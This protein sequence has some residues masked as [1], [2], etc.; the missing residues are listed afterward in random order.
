MAKEVLFKGKTIQELKELDT[1]EFAKLVKSRTRRAI[2]R[3]TSEIEKFVAK[4]IQNSSK[5][6]P[7]KTQTR[8]LVVVPRMVG[9]NIGIYSGKQYIPTE[10]TLE[11]L[12][13]RLGEFCVTR[14]KVKHGAAGI[15]AT[16]SS[17]AKASKKT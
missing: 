12:G 8:E 1:R 5:N 11:M 4:C 17:M 7:I 16:K 3:Q 15:G 10:I 9:Y 14:Q 6:K 13:H 2:L